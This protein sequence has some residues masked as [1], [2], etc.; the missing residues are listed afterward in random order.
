MY[1]FTLTEYYLVG[2]IIFCLMLSFIKTES[3][4]WD[5]KDSSGVKMLALHATDPGWTPIITQGP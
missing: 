5:W 3:Q 4:S 1:R 2:I